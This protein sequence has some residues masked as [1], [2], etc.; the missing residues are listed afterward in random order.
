MGIKPFDIVE[1]NGD[2]YRIK[3][4]DRK[5]NI[6]LVDGPWV[7]ECDITLIES[8]T[9][10]KF[11]IGDEVVINPITSIE[12]RDYPCTWITQMEQMTNGQVYTIRQHDTLD[13]TYLIGHF[14]FAPY[15]LTKIND[16]DIV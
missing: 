2:H 12:Q 5:G 14:W 10:P 11:K 4:I 3:R 8:V 13:N 7:S 9:V 1:F 6:R 15:H 16:Y